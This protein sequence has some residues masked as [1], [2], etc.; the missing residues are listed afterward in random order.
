MIPKELLNHALYAASKQYSEANAK[1]VEGQIFLNPLN[2][3]QDYNIPQVYEPFMIGSQFKWLTKTVF[4]N[5]RL[6]ADCEI[7]IFGEH[8][9]IYY[10]L[11]GEPDNYD[12]V[13]LVREN[14]I[15]DFCLKALPILNGDIVDDS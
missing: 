11:S 8:G 4:E 13:V 15:I 10:W 9:K 2:K 5:G 6:H 7:T 12:K 14:N 1:L 3:K